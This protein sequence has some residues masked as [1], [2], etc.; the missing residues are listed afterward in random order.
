RYV[1]GGPDLAAGVLAVAV[2][3][4]V[5]DGERVLGLAGDDFLAEELPD[6]VVIDRQAVL[7]EDRVPELLE[8][9]QDFV[10]DAGIVVFCLNDPAATE[11]V[12]ALEL[13]QHVASG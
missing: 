4:D 2:L 9:F 7:R 11:T 1:L 5:V 12:L 13:F 10:V 3:P 6:D 8:F